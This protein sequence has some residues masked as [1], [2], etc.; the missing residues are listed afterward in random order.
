MAQV[1]ERRQITGGV[2]GRRLV[3]ASKGAAEHDKLKGYGI[4]GLWN[5]AGN[6]LSRRWE[7]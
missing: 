4:D 1:K 5:R 6:S 3:S 2:C 7:C